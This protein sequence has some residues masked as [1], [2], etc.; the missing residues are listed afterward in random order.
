[1]KQNYGHFNGT[2]TA[3]SYHKW[4]H[5]SKIL[6]MKGNNRIH[7][8]VLYM[9]WLVHAQ[10]ISTK[11]LL[12]RTNLFQAQHQLSMH[13]SPQIKLNKKCETIPKKRANF[14]RNIV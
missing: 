1:M 3:A 14:F 10:L 11:I 8:S 12:C 6:T 2:R 7:L 13:Y 9:N 4:P 5:T